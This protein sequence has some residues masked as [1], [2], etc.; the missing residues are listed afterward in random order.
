MLRD[1]ESLWTDLIDNPS[2]ATYQ[3]PPAAFQAQKHS[4]NRTKASPAN[5]DSTQD[6]IADQI[7][8]FALYFTPSLKSASMFANDRNV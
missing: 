6:G 3:H 4:Y 8:D 1:Q 7:T 5:R 2:L